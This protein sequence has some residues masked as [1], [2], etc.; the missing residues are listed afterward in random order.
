[1]KVTVIRLV[2]GV[3]GAVHKSLEKG[4]EIEGGVVTRLQEKTETYTSNEKYKNLVNA[5]LEAA[6][7][8]IPTKQRTKS[9]VPWETLA[10]RE[11]VLTWKLPPNTKGKT[12]PIPMPW[13]LKRHKMN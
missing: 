8:F 3:L 5:H 11:S 10:V 9:R 12:Q 4:L 7:E 6:V 13:N 2:T 1:M